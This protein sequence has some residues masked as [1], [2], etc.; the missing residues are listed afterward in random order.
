MFYARSPNRKKKKKLKKKNE[1]KTEE[2]EL[3]EQA[4]ALKKKKEEGLSLMIIL[5][6]CKALVMRLKALNIYN[7]I[8]YII[9]PSQLRQAYERRGTQFINS[10]V[11]ISSTDHVAH[12][13]GL[14]VA[15]GPKGKHQHE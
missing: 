15:T 7:I 11:K 3:K 4:E 2:E 6:I 14:P 13:Q 1:R 10:Q 8:T 5:A 12:S 9:I